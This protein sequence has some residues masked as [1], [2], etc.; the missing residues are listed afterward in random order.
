MTLKKIPIRLREQPL[1]GA[2]RHASLQHCPAMPSHNS[3]TDS[4]PEFRKNLLRPY[5]GFCFIKSDHVLV[6]S[7]RYT[8]SE[9]V[10]YLV[11]DGH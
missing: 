4:Q 9:I 10:M 1:L 2:M 11:I 3:N 5:Q 7:R 8:V 6:C